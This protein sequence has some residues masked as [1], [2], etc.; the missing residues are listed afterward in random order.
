MGE[1]GGAKEAEA[2]NEAKDAVGWRRSE[3]W[4]G[5]EERVWEKGGG[6]GEGVREGVA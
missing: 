5:V 2:R 1:G 3:G 4:G 6:V